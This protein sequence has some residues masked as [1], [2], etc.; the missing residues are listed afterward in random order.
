MAEYFLSYFKIRN[1]GGLK[2][3]NSQFSKPFTGVATTRAGARLAHFAVVADTPH[4]E[5]IGGLP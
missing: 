1:F 5:G 3:L 2:F 4:V